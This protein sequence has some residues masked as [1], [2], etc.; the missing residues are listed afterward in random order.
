M[1]FDTLIR[2]VMKW[3]NPLANTC[4]EKNLNNAVAKKVTVSFKI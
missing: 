3:N 1:K 2:K 4:T